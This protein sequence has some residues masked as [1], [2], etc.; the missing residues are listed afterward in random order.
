MNF[1][2]N[3]TKINIFKIE[4]SINSLILMFILTLINKSLNFR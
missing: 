2:L 1:D 4:N 3:K